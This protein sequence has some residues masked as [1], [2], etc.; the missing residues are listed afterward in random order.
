MKKIIF[1]VCFLVF[2]LFFTVT[3]CFADETGNELNNNLSE[4]T[5]PNNIKNNNRDIT[6]IPKASSED[7]FGDEQAFPFIAGLGKNAAH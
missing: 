4:K 5:K 1:V 6:D 2:S 7:I 3:D